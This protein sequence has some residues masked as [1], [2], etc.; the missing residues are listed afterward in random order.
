MP[1]M[2]ARCSV[3]PSDLLVVPASAVKLAPG[4]V[5]FSTTLTTPAIA[6]EPYS[7]EA[8][9]FSPSRCAS[10]GQRDT[11]RKTA[12]PDTRRAAGEGAAERLTQG[13]RPVGGQVTQYVGNA[14]VTGLLQI[15]RRHDLHR[16]RRLEVG[17]LD[18]GTGDDHRLQY[19]LT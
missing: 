17:T 13:A 6:S 18:D 11:D 12:Q 2:P 16:A 15:R 1:Q 10:Q 19:L 4:K 7:A 5:F 8:P 14:R 9:S 3:V